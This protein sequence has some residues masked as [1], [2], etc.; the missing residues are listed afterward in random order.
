[1]PGVVCRA[2][3]RRAAGWQQLEVAAVPDD[4][5]RQL[6]SRQH[7]PA[8]RRGPHGS[9]FGGIRHQ[10]RHGRRHLA[11]RPP[12]QGRTAGRDVRGLRGGTTAGRRQ[13]AAC[14]QGEPGVVRGRGPLPPHRAG[15]VRLQPAH[16]EPANHI[17][18]PAFARSGLHGDRGHLVRRV[19]SRKPRRCGSRRPPDVPS[20]PPR[21]PDPPQPDRGLPDG[22]VLG[23]ARRRAGGVASRPSGEPRRGRCRSRH[24]GDGLCHPT[25][26]DLPGRHRAL[27]R[28]A[29]AGM[30]PDRR[31]RAC[32]DPGED[33]A[34]ARPLGSQGLHQADVGG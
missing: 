24:D 6:A 18:Q 14:C 3:R 20:L 25:G 9:L 11:G 22:P 16:P 17:R 19:G 4:Q 32:R 12:G 23:R 33:R 8:G 26:S 5:M 15:A 28:R 1:M 27:E 21:R 31:L 34:P 30:G 10:A 13:P 29:R 2:S 7:R